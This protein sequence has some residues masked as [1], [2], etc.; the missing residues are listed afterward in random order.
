LKMY[1]GHGESAHYYG[2]ITELDEQVGRLQEKLKALGVYGNTVQFFTSDNG[3]EG[4]RPAEG[5]LR[6]GTAGEFS[7]RKRDLYDGGVRVPTL[8]VWPGQIKAGGII[9]VPASTLD[10]F[11]TIAK[12]VDQPLADRPYD[13]IDMM[14]I[15]KG[16]MVERTTAIPFRYGSLASLVWKKYKLISNNSSSSENDVLYDLSKDV[17]EQT[18][19]IEQYPEVAMEMKKKI[20][21]FSESANSS[22]S[23]ED[24]AEEGF[25]SGEKYKAFKEGKGEIRPKENV[26]N[27]KKKKTK[28]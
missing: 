11:P 7:G 14:P 25:K 20:L 2:C 17:K 26:K 18:N 9:D 10:Y 23:G 21:A 6:A 12:I 28:K 3:P 15:A 24:Y 13:G 5:A 4:P 8:M 1:E 16:E 22:H 19:L 27:K